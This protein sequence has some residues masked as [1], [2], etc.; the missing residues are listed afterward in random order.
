MFPWFL[1][2][3]TIPHLDAIGSAAFRLLC[4]AGQ[5]LVDDGVAGGMDHLGRNGWAGDGI[6]GSIGR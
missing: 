1:G 6:F 5:Q 4:C 2:T 3:L